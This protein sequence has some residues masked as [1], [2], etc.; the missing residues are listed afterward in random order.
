VALACPS[1]LAA[2]VGGVARAWLF[3]TKITEQR[4]PDRAVPGGGRRRGP[5]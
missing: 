1:W 5:A 2:L 3:L 4:V